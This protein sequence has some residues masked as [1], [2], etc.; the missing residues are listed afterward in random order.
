MGCVMQ[1]ACLHVTGQ[2]DDEHAQKACEQ[3][4]KHQAAGRCLGSCCHTVLQS[5]APDGGFSLRLAGLLTCGSA[6]LIAFPEIF[7]VAG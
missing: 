4:G 1:R 7:R 3:S 6:G 5:V 2:G